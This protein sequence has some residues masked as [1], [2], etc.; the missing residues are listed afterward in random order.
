[1]KK[2]S[3]TAPG[4]RSGTPGP[5][6][7]RKSKVG[8]GSTSDGEA[9]AGEMSDSAGPR[10]KIKLVGSAKGTPSASRAGSPVPATGGMFC[11]HISNPIVVAVILTISEQVHLHPPKLVASSPGK[12]WK[13]FLLKGLPLAISS[14]HFKVVSGTGLARWRNRTGSKWL[15]SFANMALTDFCED[16]SKNIGKPEPRRVETQRRNLLLKTFSFSEGKFL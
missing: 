16:E 12:S 5:N 15:R 4:S 2:T 7:P 1:M 10:K 3:A 11:Q 8:A 9:T 14:S 13:R 6:A